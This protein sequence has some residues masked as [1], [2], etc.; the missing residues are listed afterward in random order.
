MITNRYSK[1]VATMVADKTITDSKRFLVSIN[2][3]NQI[4][5]LIYTDNFSHYEFISENDNEK[6][7]FMHI[8]PMNRKYITNGGNEYIF[9]EIL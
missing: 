2:N 5:N 6:H 8:P 1:I 4:L 3:I 9:K 7:I